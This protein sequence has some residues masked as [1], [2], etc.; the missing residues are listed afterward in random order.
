MYTGFTT[1]DLAAR[2]DLTLLRP[3]ATI[4]EVTAFATEALT[5]PFAALF[6]PPCHVGL[7]AKILE[8]SSIKVGAPVGYPLG[9][10][11]AESKVLE[12]MEA[13]NSG[14]TEIDMVMNL[15]LFKSGE[16]DAVT[17]EIAAVKAAISDLVLKVI[18]ETCYLDAG[19]MREAVE[20]ITEA[21]ADFVKTSTGLGPGGATAEDVKLLVEAAAGRIKVKASGGVSSL[22]SVIEMLDAGADKIGTSAGIEIL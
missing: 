6:I 1:D 3:T 16:R 2:F 17:Q 21:G 14:A 15:S 13:V 10:Q 4:D 5:Y 11:S 8:G 20:I 22:A 12:A 19:E 9:F 18:I 7:V